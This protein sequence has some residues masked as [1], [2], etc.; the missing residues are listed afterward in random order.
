MRLSPQ[1]LPHQRAHQQ[2]G[3]F[4][5]LLIVHTCE[6][7]SV[8]AVSLVRAK[9]GFNGMIVISTNV[10][11]VLPL[12]RR[13]PHTVSA[14]LNF[15]HTHGHHTRISPDT[16]TSSPEHATGKTLSAPQRQPPGWPRMA[17]GTMHPVSQEARRSHPVL[18]SPPHTLPTL[19]PPA[20]SSLTHRLRDVRGR[21]YHPRTQ[22]LHMAAMQSGCMKAQAG[23]KGCS[24][25]SPKSSHSP[26]FT[27]THLA[28]SGRA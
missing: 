13:I 6:C 11:P 2:C 12:P 25:W 19:S 4:R 14:C 26:A 24:R 22:C 20:T 1:A 10:G 8:T 9:G 15:T 16:D 21:V 28:G 23:K 5:F 27:H 18:S 17:P 7:L 3:K